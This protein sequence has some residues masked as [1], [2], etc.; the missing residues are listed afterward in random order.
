MRLVISVV[1]V[2]TAAILILTAMPASGSQEVVSLRD[3]SVSLDFGNKDVTIEPMHSSSTMDTVLHSITFRGDNETDFATVYLYEYAVPQM[4]DLQDRLRSFMKSSCTMVDIDPA[5]VSGMSGYIGTGR[6][7]V[8]HGFS[9]Q[10]CYGGIASLPSGAVGQRD[11]LIIS[12]FV[13]EALNEKLVKT[14]HIEY[15]GKTV[16]I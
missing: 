10:I 13:D 11:F 12:H 4:F 3:Y 16:K 1:L 8:E 6:A 5:M 14:A 7:R 15:A 2:I 9:K